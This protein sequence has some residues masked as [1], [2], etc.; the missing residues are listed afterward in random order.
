MA[1]VLGTVILFMVF[2]V[3]K[4]LLDSYST[5][6]RKVGTHSGRFAGAASIQLSI[7]L[8]PLAI[9]FVMYTLA[10]VLPI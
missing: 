2:V 6:S 7:A 10:R 1:L 5:D 3:F 9:V 4:T 8:A